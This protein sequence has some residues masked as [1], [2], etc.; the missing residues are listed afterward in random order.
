MFLH[1]AKGEL[2][3]ILCNV[4]DKNFKV[5][6]AT[7]EKLF[8]EKFEEPPIGLTEDLSDV[9]QSLTIP[10]FAFTKSLIKGGK[11]M[12]QDCID[13]SEKLSP[14]IMEEIK[15]HPIF[16][17]VEP[18]KGK[19][20]INV[21]YKSSFLGQYLYQV[22]DK[23]FTNWLEDQKDSV[24]IEYSQPNTHKTFHV[25]HMRNASLGMSL[26]K[27]FEFNKF[28]VSAVNYIGDVGTHIA[29]CLWY[30]YNYQDQNNTID[31]NFLIYQKN[32]KEK[33][34]KE[35]KP[36][37][38]ITKV[39]YLGD[40][41]ALATDM[42]DFSQWT[43]YVNPGVYTFKIIE[44]KDHQVNPKW[45]ILKVTDEKNT[46]TVVC[47]GKGYKLDDIVA[48]VPIGSKKGG[49]VIQETDFKGVTSF[50]L[51]MSE[52]ELDKGQDK[53]KIYIFPIGTPLGI[54][55][56][57]VERTKTC[58]TEIKSISEEMKKRNEG[59]RNVLKQM[60]NHE[61]KV[62]K[63]WEYTRKWCI[64]EFKEIYEWTDCRFDHY[65]H[66][67][68]VGDESKEIVIDA[69]N[70]GI[71]QKSDGAI[72]IDLGKQYGYCVLLTSDGTGL[73]ATKDIALAKKKFEEF[74]I[75]RS[76]YVVDAAQTLHFQQV[77]KVLEKLGFK[78]APKCYH[79]PYGIVTLPDGK[80]SS[81][82][83]NIITFAS[84]KERLVD[85]IM[86]DYL[87]KY[88]GK[89]PDQEIAHVCQRIAVSI[90]KYG[91]LKMD[92]NKDIIFILKE[93]SAKTGNTGPYLMYAYSRTRSIL[94][95]VQLTDEEK[96]IKIDVSLLNHPKEKKVLM[97][98]NSFLPQ[99]KMACEQYKPHI[100]CNYLFCLAK[101]F[102]R[103][104]E[105]ISVKNAE[106][107]ELKVARLLL[108]DCVGII[109]QQGLD[110]LGIQTVE[111]M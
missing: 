92:S 86:N 25:G 29:K 105:E 6:I 55:L 31:E 90:I 26:V 42:L 100:I 77:F 68:D 36:E 74:K 3:K 61:E 57:E 17:K 12:Q 5:D 73:Y 35:G 45:K 56:T 107:P 99:A 9:G 62:T 71:L 2:F 19:P 82:K 46:F 108:V 7:Q 59:V 91:M 34:K 89:W 11:T 97:I 96:L 64:D 76:I 109:L 16:E 60:E 10:M 41:Y 75:D 87:D 47:G 38:D 88:K 13:L 14:L 44:I 72:G 4:V 49:R 58:P 51:I 32:Y 39:E 37:R 78:Q 81:R 33:L 40:M 27:L 66:E 8:V 79:L 80:M 83:G 28:K 1:K 70:K 98:L 53:D 23:S 43:K 63:L 84:L 21:F 50:G 52:A 67:S 93:W 94:R 18:T 69:Y 65:F 85:C 104:Y 54:E 103:M 15:N 20:Y 24:M 95:E 30:Y 111:R 22:K 106:T 102:S 48:Y 110:L 101:N